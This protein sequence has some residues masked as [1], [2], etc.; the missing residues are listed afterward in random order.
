MKVAAIAGLTS[1][2]GL[3][4][5]APAF[6]D[7]HLFTAV[8]A[9]GL[10]TQSNPFTK[11]NGRSG[12]SVPGQGSPLS[13]EDQTVPAVATD[14]ISTQANPGNGVLRTPPPVLDSKVAPSSNSPH[15]GL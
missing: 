14:E 5:A 1:T 3:V 7:D 4:T 15:P 2:L 6:A 13:G 9:G 12:A 11:T 8:A 10:T